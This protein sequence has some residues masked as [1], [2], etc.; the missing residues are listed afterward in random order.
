MMDF[1][2]SV[3]SIIVLAI[4]TCLQLAELKKKTCHFEKLYFIQKIRQVMHFL[5]IAINNLIVC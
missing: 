1:I 3:K 5:G 2:N 4:Q